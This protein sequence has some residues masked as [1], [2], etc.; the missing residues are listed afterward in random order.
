MSRDR[1]RGHDAPLS[2]L[3]SAYQAGRLGQAYLFAGPDGIGKRLFAKELAKA[4]LCDRP[5]GPLAACDDCP[6]CA[7]VEAGTHPDVFAV[8]TPPGKHELPIEDI[9]EFTA[10]VAMKPS[11]GGR[12]VGLVETADDFNNQSAN[13]FLKTLEEPPPGSVLILLATDTDR[14]LPT[15]LS[16]CQVVRF[17]PPG[18]ADLRAVLADNGV[19]PDRLDRLVRLADGSPARGLT[20]NDD[21]VWAVRKRLLDGVTA[22]RPNFAAL[23][24]AWQGFYEAAGKDTAAQRVR[25]SLVVG[26]LVGAVQLALRLSVGAEVPELDPDEAGRLRAFADRLGPDRLAELLDRLVDADNHID[27]RAQLP[28]VVEAVLEQFTRPPPVRV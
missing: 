26:F 17:A 15:I 22:P 20:L 5:P 27:R 13:A 28:L 10:R 16:R 11:R 12:K 8:R 19:E 6:A 7:Q 18:P 24:E 3:R 9:R 4:L 14:Q 23:A 2:S 1:V 25:A 21:A